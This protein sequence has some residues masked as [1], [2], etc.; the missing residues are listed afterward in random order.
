MHKLYPRLVGWGIIGLVLLVTASPSWANV[1]I[2][3]FSA[4]WQNSR[5][6]VEWKTGTEKDFVGYNIYRSESASGPFTKI[7]YES[8]PECMLQI[9]G[10]QYSVVDSAV[11]PGKTYYYQLES[12]NVSNQTQRHSTTAVAQPSATSTAT[13][14]PPTATP[15]R[16]STRTATNAPNIP[17]STSAPPTATATPLPQFTPTRTRT[18]PPGVTPP[19]LAPP[20][21]T[22]R[23]A[24]IAQPSATRASVLAPAAPSIAPSEPTRVAIAIKEPELE[25]TEEVPDE[26]T[27][28]ESNESD[29]R[30]R[31][32]IVGAMILGM[33]VLGAGGLV[34]G[35]VAVYLAFRR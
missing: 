30:T 21:P 20:T 17:T 13:P 22:L 12:V 18:L 27:I 11:T 24:Y 16:T 8:R 10:C 9:I 7:R 35:L 2:S 31:Q 1:T 33:G 5:V 4:K 15:T 28:A 29:V 14:A 32:L 34:L 23:V 26:D 19:T 6:I 3:N 25:E